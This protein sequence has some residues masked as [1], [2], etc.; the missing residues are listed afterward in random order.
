MK[1]LCHT[2]TGHTFD[3][4][5]PEPEDIRPLDIAVALCRQ[6][7]FC[8]HT[9]VPYSVADHS[10][11][12][13]SVLPK[14]H[15]LAALL[16]D[17]SEAYICDLNRQVKHLGSFGGYRDIELRLNV[18]IQIRFDVLFLGVKAI[19]DADLRV[20]RAEA[21]Q[22]FEEWPEK[23]TRREKISLQTGTTAEQFYNLLHECH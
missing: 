19:K 14:K 11:N 16:H 8:G 21:Q 22:L 17:A 6:P 15:K 23:F 13:A 10:V 20:F 4:L 18:A 7:R 5:R 9:L 12:V 1:A 3:L 2:Y